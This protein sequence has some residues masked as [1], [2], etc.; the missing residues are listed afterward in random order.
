MAVPVNARPGQ[1]DG[2]LAGLVDLDDLIHRIARGEKE[3][4]GNALLVDMKGN[5]VIYAGEAN[6][7][8]NTDPNSLPLIAAFHGG[9]KGPILFS[10]SHGEPSVGQVLQTAS[11]WEVAIQIPEKEALD[12]LNQAQSAYLSLLGATLIMGMLMALLFAWLFTKPI[13]DLTR[14]ADGIS[15]GEQMPLDACTNRKDEIGD[16]A[17]AISRMQESIRISMERLRRHRKSS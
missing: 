17:K 10:D 1:I 3:S 15:M 8:Q 16:L 14:T 4:N 12:G 11:G 7:V 9:Q 5:R 2:I 13:R 6:T